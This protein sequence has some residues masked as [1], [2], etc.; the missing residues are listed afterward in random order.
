MTGCPSCGSGTTRSGLCRDCQ[1]LEDAEEWFAVD[2]DQD[3]PECPR[4]ERESS[5]EAVVCYRCRG[6]D[7]GDGR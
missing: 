2:A 7:G 4:C 3:V 1:L 6:D 5:G